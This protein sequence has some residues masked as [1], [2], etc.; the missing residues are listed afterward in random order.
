MGRCGAVLPGAELTLRWLA[1]GAARGV[2]GVVK[3]MKKL[4]LRG[5]ETLGETW[6][7]FASLEDPQ[8]RR[9][10]LDT[11]R[12]VIDLRGQRLDA[13]DRLYLAEGLPTLIIWG[14]KDPLIPVSHALHSHAL[15][16]GSRLEIFPDAGH[17]PYRDEPERFAA[18]LLDFIHTTAPRPFDVNHLRSRLRAGPAAHPA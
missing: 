3:A 7:S 13:S 14:A 12:S 18:V 2:D 9:A 4:G 1:A 16:P 17:F 6:R 8:A 10:F 11:V 15:L 5:S